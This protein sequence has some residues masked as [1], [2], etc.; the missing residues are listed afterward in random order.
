VIPPL[1]TLVIFVVP[2]LCPPLHHLVIVLHI[3]TCLRRREG[4][5]NRSLELSQ[6]DDQRRAS[7]EA[8]HDRVAHEVDEVAEI[9]EA[10]DDQDDATTER[11]LSCSVNS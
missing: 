3:S 6:A 5:A 7:G 11:C 8:R 10:E 9:K 2:V 1:V 4:E